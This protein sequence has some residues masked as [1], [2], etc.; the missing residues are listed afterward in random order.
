MSASLIQ[1]QMKVEGFFWVSFICCFSRSYSVR[2]QATGG[3]TFC[4]QRIKG[5][6]LIPKL[7]QMDSLNDESA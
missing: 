4:I 3:T 1:L 7:S 2:F 6:F 5:L